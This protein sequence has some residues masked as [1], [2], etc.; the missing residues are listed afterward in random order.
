M[1]VTRTDSKVITVKPMHDPCIMNISEIPA[2]NAQ[3]DAKSKWMAI[4]FDANPYQTVIATAKLQLQQ[5]A[6]RARFT[7]TRE[8]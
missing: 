7:V 8:G 6:I 4:Q 1:Y 3:V 5:T 2:A